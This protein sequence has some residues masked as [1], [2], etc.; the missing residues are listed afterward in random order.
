MK[1]AVTTKKAHRKFA[2]SPL[3]LVYVDKNCKLFFPVQSSNPQSVRMQTQLSMQENPIDLFLQKEGDMGT[4][5]SKKLRYMKLQLAMLSLL[6]SGSF[7]SPFEICL[8]QE[9]P[10]T[11]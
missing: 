11:S 3:P 5:N 1:S 7:L 10:T 4:G 2:I 8:N 9:C 6:L